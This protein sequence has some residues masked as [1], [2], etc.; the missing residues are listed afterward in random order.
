MADQQRHKVRESSFWRAYFQI[1]YTVLFY[2]MLLML[3]LLPVAGL[4]GLPQNG[5]KLLLGACL[6]AAV[7]PSAR[8]RTR[9]AMIAGVI[10]L[11]IARL[12]SE[13]GAFPVNFGLVLALFGVV[14][15]SAAASALRF[16]INSERVDQQTIYAALSTY[17][18]AG[19]FFGLIYQ[20]LEFIWPGSISSPEK[21]TDESA[22]YFSFVTLASLG[23]GD[24]LPVSGL[25]RG[26]A[27]FEVI[28]GQLFLVVM[29]ARLVG[30]FVDQKEAR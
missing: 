16:V 8:G 3:V 24:I 9:Y 30:L 1:R 28:G 20:A 26:V 13:R 5:L 2:S 14:G 6:L 21:L 4:F 23:Y 12:A 7:L 25:A 11:V 19:L 18:L 10:A 22:A 29:V 15:L 17:L 27:I